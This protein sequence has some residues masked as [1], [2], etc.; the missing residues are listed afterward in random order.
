[1][2]EAYAILRQRIVALEC[3]KIAPEMALGRRST[4][5]KAL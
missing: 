4:L 3:V 5:R 2:L 1:M